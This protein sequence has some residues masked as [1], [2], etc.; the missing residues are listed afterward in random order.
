VLTGDI[1]TF[2]ADGNWRNRVVGGDQLPGC[3]RTREVAAELGAAIA[4]ALDVNHVDTSPRQ[5]SRGRWSGRTSGAARR[6]L[7]LGVEHFHP[8]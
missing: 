3:Y 2:N 1:E 6:G 8:A 7:G 4:Q 5:G